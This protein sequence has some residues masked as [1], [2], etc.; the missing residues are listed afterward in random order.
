MHLPSCSTLPSPPGSPAPPGLTDSTHPSQAPNLLS[1]WLSSP[2]LLSAFYFLHF[3]PECWTIL[4]GSA[5]LYVFIYSEGVLILTSASSNHRQMWYCH[6]LP[7][8]SSGFL[9][10]CCPQGSVYI[11]PCPPAFDHTCLPPQPFLPVFCQDWTTEVPEHFIYFPTSK[12]CTYYVPRTLEPPWQFLLHAPGNT[13]S[14]LAWKA[15]ALCRLSLTPPCVGVCV[16]G[17]L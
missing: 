1:L 9:S 17:S 4:T 2:F 13:G 16:W 12:D 15:C 8:L 3:R 5:G 10:F 11:L 14:I 7:Q 6:V